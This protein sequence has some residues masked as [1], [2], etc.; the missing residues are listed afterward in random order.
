[1]PFL[2]SIIIGRSNTSTPLFRSHRQPRHATLEKRFPLWEQ[3]MDSWDLSAQL[4]ARLA[5]AAFAAYVIYF[6]VFRKRSE[7]AIRLRRGSVTFRGRVPV[8]M[9]PGITQFLLQDLSLM[10]P[11]SIYGAWTNRRLRIW[12]RGSLTDGEKQRIRNFLLGRL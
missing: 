11:V 10:E 4:L 5:V 7:F 1:L 2:R 9:Q 6:F 12:F 8:A 3:A